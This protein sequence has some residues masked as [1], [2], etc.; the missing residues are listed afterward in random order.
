MKLLLVI[1]TTVFTF[2]ATA[3]TQL[4]CWN[5]YSKKGSR[6]ILRAKI[7]RKTTL[8]G[9]T[10]DLKSALF[11]D[12]FIDKV[13]DAG[14]NWG[15][16]PEITKSELYNPEED[17]KAEEITTARSPYQGNNE[18]AFELGSYSFKSPYH[19]RKGTYDVRLI[20]PQDLSN[21]NLK[22]FRIRTASERSNAVMIYPS[23]Y[24]SSQSGNNNL[25]MFCVSK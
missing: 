1:L 19:N 22:T 9:V 10:F 20:L 5:I 21:A 2:G 12:Y 16:K 14:E 17:L 7:K 8:S 4:S 3:E 13:G 23:F 11:E 25:K 15:H 24:G 6:P 18:Y